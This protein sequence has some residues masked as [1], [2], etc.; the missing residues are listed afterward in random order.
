MLAFF[1]SREQNYQFAKFGAARRSIV[2]GNMI[3][4][5]LKT[6]ILFS[7]AVAGALNV[8]QFF[9]TYTQRESAFAP[10]WA[11]A[12]SEQPAPSPA[13]AATVV[14]QPATQTVVVG[15]SNPTPEASAQE[16]A[17][18]PDPDAAAIAVRLASAGLNPNYASLYLAA[19]DKTGTPWQLLAAIHHVETGQSGNTYRSSYAGATGP[20]QFMPATFAHYAIDGNGDGAPDIN[21]AADAIFTA[22]NYLRAGG[23]DKG[24]YSTAVYHYNHSYTYVDRVLGIAHNLGL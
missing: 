1:L 14:A 11:Q 4:L 20:M 15:D 18:A 12:A 19:Q 23:A 5:N 2:S 7:S 24:D 9:S 21:N 13:S 3:K 17:P 10:S 16:A 8:G 6:T 22:G